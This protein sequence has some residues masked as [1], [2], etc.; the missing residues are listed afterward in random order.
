MKVGHLSSLHDFLFSN[1]NAFGEYTPIKHVN[2]YITYE[3]LY[4]CCVL[5]HGIPLLLKGSSFKQDVVR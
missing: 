1:A 2:V 5:K 4:K 3:A